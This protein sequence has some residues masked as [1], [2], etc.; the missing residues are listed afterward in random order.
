MDWFVLTGERTDRSAGI[1]WEASY[2]SRAG[3]GRL[4]RVDRPLGG[5]A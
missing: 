1:A 2:R 3:S 4:E 5:G